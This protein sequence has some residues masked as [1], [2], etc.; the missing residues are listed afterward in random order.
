MD[1][2]KSV[3]IIDDHPLFREGLKTII[4]RNAV[5]EVLGEAGSGNEGLKQANKLKPD[6]IILDI[7]LPDK[8]GLHILREIRRLLP[9]T[10][11][12]IVSMYS[13]MDYIKEAFKSGATGYVVKDSAS[14]RLISGLDSVIKGEHY[15]DSTISKKV[16]EQMI[17]TPLKGYRTL[18]PAYGSLSPREQ[19]V[20]RMVAEGLST[21][22]IAEKL[23][24]S[25]K[26]VENHRA[27]I[28]GKLEVHNTVELVRYA[29]KIGLIDV[30]LWKE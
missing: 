25:P 7:S 15:L 4:N 2:R 28:M 8:S 1:K 19:E 29:A 23:C 5:Y 21:K 17:K 22:Q 12:M 6:V 10:K 18:D 26:T 24:I 13:K 16:M 9:N 3:L 30:D 14:E 27:K 11:V 20:M